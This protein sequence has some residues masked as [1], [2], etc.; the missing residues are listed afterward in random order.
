MRYYFSG[1]STDK[2]GHC[3]EFHE[4]DGSVRLQHRTE[5]R[6][7]QSYVH[8][9]AN[10]EAD[11][12]LGILRPPNDAALPSNIECWLQPHPALG[13]ACTV[14]KLPEVGII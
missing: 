10:S 11:Y 8:V 13:A 6:F 3:G 2:F 4:A 5:R 1:F 12:R 9:P 7:V 14:S